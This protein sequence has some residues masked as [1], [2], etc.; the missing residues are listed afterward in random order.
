METAARAEVLEARTAADDVIA[1]AEALVDR[2]G[3]ALARIESE[4]GVLADT[5]EQRDAQLTA[6]QREVQ[7]R[8]DRAQGIERDA[9]HKTAS[10]REEL[11]TRAGVRGAELIAQ[12]SHAWLDEARGRAAAAIRA[13]DATATDPA[14]DREARRVMEVAASRYQHHYLTERSASNLRIGSTTARRCT[15][16]SSVSPVSSCRSTTRGTRS[17]STASTVS[18]R[19][20]CGGRSTSS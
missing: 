14:H 1:R 4:L 3:D 2:R 10:A 18:A 6:T 15:V 5:I 9:E 11:E 12:M 19:S 8:R 20:S 7:S 16:R 13:I 17:G